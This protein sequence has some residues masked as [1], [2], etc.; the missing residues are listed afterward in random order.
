MSL[1][2]CM[3]VKNEAE[4]LPDCLAS[5]GDLPQEIVVC[6][7]GSTDETVAVA[8][9][10]G[11]TVQEI[12][13]TDDFAAARNAS[14]KFVTCDWV[15]IL[16]ADETLTEEGRLFLKTLLAGK[17]IH[18]IEP[19]DLLL[20]TWLRQEVGA[21]QSPYTQVS[22]LFRNH[23]QLSFCRPYH[24]TV[25]ESA[26][27]LL[28]QDPHWKVAQLP[29]VAMDHTGYTATA[30]AI[31]QK[32][33][34]AQTLMEAHLANHPEDAYLCNKLGALYGQQGDWE[35]GINWLNQGLA[36]PQAVDP[37]T[38]YELHYHVGLA[39]RHLNQL[40]QAADHYQKALAQKI[41]EPLKLGALL[42]LGSLRKHQGQFL[43]A[44]SLFEALLDI[45]D[46]QAVAYY[47]LGVAQRARGYLEPAIEAYQQAIKLDPA[48]AEAHQNLGVVWFK[49]GKLKESK[50]A[51]QRAIQFYQKSNPAEAVRL[52]QGIQGLG[53]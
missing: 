33:E 37:V 10:L 8:Q 22:R 11:A 44:I 1:S 34:R 15:L 24:E 40:Q 19:E 25:D 36:S 52:Q 28:V 30:I 9:S 26:E 29:T 47:N 23:S 45:D 16:D 46:T 2:V 13:W 6:D 5:L 17:P 35:R 20:V 49:L 50:A 3:I 42:N 43:E 7:T 41:A 48:Y 51:F 12:P 21:L 14:L 39:Y 32:F 27:A 38:E 18:G 53:L 4:S 31:R